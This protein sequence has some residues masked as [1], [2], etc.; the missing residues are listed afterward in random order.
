MKKMFL[1]ILAAF[2]LQS[3][4]PSVFPGDDPGNRCTINDVK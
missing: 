2:A 4:D 1:P 3:C